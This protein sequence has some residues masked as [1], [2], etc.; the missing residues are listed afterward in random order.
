M[1]V[2]KARISGGAFVDCGLLLRLKFC[3]EASVLG[4]QL[5]HLGLESSNLDLGRA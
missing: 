2:R 4:L 3:P 5:L 1:I